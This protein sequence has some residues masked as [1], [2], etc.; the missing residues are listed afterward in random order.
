MPDGMFWHYVSISVLSRIGRRNSVSHANVNEERA[1]TMLE[2]N[3]GLSGWFAVFPRGVARWSL[4]TL[5]DAILREICGELGC[6]RLD[7]GRVGEPQ[8]PCDAD[9]IGSVLYRYARMAS[10]SARRI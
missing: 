9:Y 4:T 7:A 1:C 8:R 5:D 6:D 2:R 3:E 10:S